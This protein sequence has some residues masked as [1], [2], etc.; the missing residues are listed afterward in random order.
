[1]YHNDLFNDNIPI[2]TL[3]EAVD[4]STLHDRPQNTNRT[5]DLD[6]LRE[7][8]GC[9][10]MVG[11]EEFDSTTSSTVTFAHYTVKEF[12]NSPRVSQTK[13][14][15]FALKEW[16]IKV[17]FA[18]IVLRQ[19]LL[20]KHINL[21]AMNDI[22]GALDAHF[23]L[24]CGVSAVLQLNAWSESISSHPLLMQL[25][26][27]LVTPFTSNYDKLCDMLSMTYRD[28]ED[29]FPEDF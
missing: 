5:F 25:S 17:E 18:E 12:L 2:D 14:R 15:F 23:E 9:L 26:E 19:A 20:I 27:A 4:K 29:L 24:Y 28:R 22:N 13:A 11:Q 7:S 1:M 16:R 21:E 6:A 10:I 3:I 8:C